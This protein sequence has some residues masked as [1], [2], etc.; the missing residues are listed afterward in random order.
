MKAYGKD[1]NDYYNNYFPEGYYSEDMD[2]PDSLWTGEN[3]LNLDPHKLYD[4]EIMGE[5]IAH[6]DWTD[7][8][9]FEEKYCEW[10]NSRE[11][12]LTKT[13]EIT[14]PANDATFVKHLLEKLQIDIKEF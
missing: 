7:S 13:I 3:T 2:V 11:T 9:T 14:V 6:D 8:Y 5:I 12:P 1:I 4:L 10:A